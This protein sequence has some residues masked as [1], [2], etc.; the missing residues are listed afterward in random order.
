MLANIWTIAKK[1][2][3]KTSHLK[4]RVS[5]FSVAASVLFTIS[6]LLFISSFINTPDSDDYYENVVPDRRTILFVNAPDSF[7]EYTEKE[8]EFY[9]HPVNEQDDMTNWEGQYVR[10]ELNAYYDFIGITRLMR[11]NRA[12]MAIVFPTDFDELI[13]SK[14]ASSERPQI[15][16]YFH[17]DPAYYKDIHDL[18]I[19]YVSENY[20]LYL[21]GRLDIES[22]SGPAFHVTSEGDRGFGRSELDLRTQA[23]QMIVPLVIFI[24]ALFVSMESGV[25]AIAGEK[26]QGTFA[27]LLLTPVSRSEIILGNIL[28][29]FGKTLIPCA[30]IALVSAAVVGRFDVA[31]IAG[32]LIFIIPLALVLSSLII[33]ISVL[34]KTILAAQTSFLPIFLILLVVC[35][36]AMNDTGNLGGINLIMP[37]FGHYLG[38]AAALTGDM[39]WA[40]SVILLVISLA[41]SSAL[42]LVSV[43]LL[44]FERFT[45]TND[46][47]SDYKTRRDRARREDP[48]INYLDY[49]KSVIFGY[50]ATRWR[51]AYRLV[52]YHFTMPLLLLSVFQPIALIVPIIFFM[53]SEKSVEFIESFAAMTERLQLE[54]AVIS[55]FDLVSM[56]MREQAFIIGMAIGYV[57]IILI[58]LLIV[59]VIEK[60]P[61]STIGLPIKGKNGIGKAVAAYARGGLIGLSMITGVYL[62]LFFS[63]QIRFGGFSMDSSEWPLFFSY[64]LMWIPQGASEEVMMRG[65]MLPRVSVKF[66]KA[67]AVVLTSLLFGLLHAGNIGFTPLALFNLCL[68]AAFFALLTIRTG[69]I[70]TVC[71]AHSAWNFAQ[72]NLFGLQVSGTSAPAALMSADYTSGAR[73]LITGG[74]FGPEGGLAVTIVT[75]VAITLLYLSSRKAARAKGAPPSEPVT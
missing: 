67:G 24:A 45:T 72:G 11:D 37:F 57:G 63:G 12:F 30:S 29:V 38:M 59:R 15:L 14:N 7:I 50:R 46:A 4:S 44:G 6:I 21:N 60:N 1:T 74:D 48:K 22:D 65:Y 40:R 75:A 52:S 70:F 2:L 13:F 56:L 32:L 58:Y 28:G 64:I 10:A 39:D 9:F 16:S 73:A 61:I 35:V 62:I 8:S 55:A 31:T 33:V 25:S 19:D 49:P 3:S 23:G 68:I 69:E 51:N 34:N 71:A 43:R 47:S 26:E 66:G 36:M 53:R 18:V 54:S 5:W 42:C 41:I 27:A 17:T 20:T